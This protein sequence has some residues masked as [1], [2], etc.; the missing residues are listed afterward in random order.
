MISVQL[1]F[2][3][4]L[5]KLAGNDFGER[6][7]VEQVRPKIDYND[8]IELVF[9]ER[10]DRIASSFVQGLL[11]D[12]VDNIGIEGIRNQVAFVSSISNLK[13]FVLKNLE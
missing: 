6:I 5:T 10:I 11:G 3:S 7:F 8:T 1:E 9:P 13:D 12:I 2:R 4:D